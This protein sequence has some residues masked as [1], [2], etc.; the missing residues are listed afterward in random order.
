MGENLA[1]HASLL[2]VN[3]GPRDYHGSFDP[4]TIHNCCRFT[5]EFRASD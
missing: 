3:Q 2:S 5:L 4:L 1:E